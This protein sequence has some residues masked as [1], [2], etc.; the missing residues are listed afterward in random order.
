[1][2]QQAFSH[3]GDHLRRER[4]GVRQDDFAVDPIG[5]GHAGNQVKV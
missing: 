1:M 2:I 5:R 3:R 4:I